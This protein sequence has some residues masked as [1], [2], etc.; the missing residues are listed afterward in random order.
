MKNNNFPLHIE[1][2]Q[3]KLFRNI[4]L[5]LSREVIPSLKRQFRKEQ[6]EIKIDSFGDLENK[7]LDKVKSGS[8]Y[9]KNE[10]TKIALLI[11]SWSYFKTKK[12]IDNINKKS[13]IPIVFERENLLAEN[14]ISSFIKTNM[15]LAEILQREFIPEISKAASQTFLSGGSTKDLAKNL[16]HYTNNNVSKAE[17]WARDQVGSAYSEFTKVHQ[18]QAG[19]RSYVWR[20]AGDNAVRDNHATLEG[21][22][23]SWTEGAANTGLLTASGAKHPGE[24]YQCRCTSEPYVEN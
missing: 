7:L 2:Q 14:F 10:I 4:I 9:L 18:V 16:L 8:K 21:R 6:K 20:T 3:A 5:R 1:H 19:F 12:M 24:D 22:V 11:E 23:F 15:E 17:F 13:I